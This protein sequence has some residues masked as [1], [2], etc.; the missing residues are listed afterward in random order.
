MSE[1]GRMEGGGGGG[2]EKE[3]E[4]EKSTR[5]LVRIMQGRTN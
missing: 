5:Q 2:G 1:E 3:K 4:E